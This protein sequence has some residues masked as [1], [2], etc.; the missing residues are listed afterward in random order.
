MTPLALLLWTTLPGCGGDAPDP[1][2][3]AAPAPFDLAECAV[4]GMVVREQPAPRGQVLRRDGTREHACS[5]GDLRALA[6]IPSP[7]GKAVA[8]WVE[9][10]PPG[11]APDALGTAPLP[12]LPAEQAWYVAGFERPLVM[13]VPLLS[14]AEPDA[15]RTAAQGL[16]GHVS[17]WEQVAGASF[18]QVPPPA[19]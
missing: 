19:P 18:D 14:Y 12:W 15:A 10:V 13:G 1:V 11:V 16:R 6:E 5:L 3:T 9:A 4:C 17:R 7:H 8:A 2:E